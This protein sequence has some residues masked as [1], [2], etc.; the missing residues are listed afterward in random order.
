MSNR[1]DYP[2]IGG[3]PIDGGLDAIAQLAEELTE[4]LAKERQLTQ[5][6]GVALREVMP[7][8]ERGRESLIMTSA[9]SSENKDLNQRAVLADQAVQRAQCALNALGACHLSVEMLPATYF[10]DQFE[11]KFEE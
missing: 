6:L 11:V 3:N 1:E 7:V 2:T 4:D 10:D 8:A 9:N 5:F